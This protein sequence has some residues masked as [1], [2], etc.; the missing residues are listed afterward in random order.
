MC[1]AGASLPAPLITGPAL[2]AREAEGLTWWK[3]SRRRAS[4][5][6]KPSKRRAGG[7]FAG[8]EPKPAIAVGPAEMLLPL[9]LVERARREI[10]RALLE[11]RIMLCLVQNGLPS[12]AKADGKTKSSATGALD[13]SGG[14]LLRLDWR[15]YRRVGSARARPR[16]DKRS[17]DQH[18][19]EAQES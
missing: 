16:L 15:K 11:L 12:S 6:R 2:F 1:R 13:P 4:G 17:A 9:G 3:R 8:V 18:R 19:S 14:R 7:T 5:S 10:A